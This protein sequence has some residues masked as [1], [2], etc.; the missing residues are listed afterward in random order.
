MTVAPR[1]WV[2]EIAPYR[3]GKRADDEDGGLASNEGS[4]IS[5]AIADAVLRALTTLHRYP[6]PLASD[7]RARIAAHHGVGVDEVLV[8]GG[9]D[10]LL[11]LL[12]LAYAAQGSV[13]CGDPGYWGHRIPPQVAGAEVRLVRLTDHRHDLGSMALVEADIAFI[14]NPHNPTGTAVSVDD[15]E[16]FSRS[17]RARL[18]V[19][20]EAYIECA[21]DPTSLSSIPLSTTTD[22]VVLRTF[23]KLYG[24][25]GA[26]VGYAVGPAAVIE[27]LAA[28]R[29]PFSVNALGQAAA[30]AALGDVEHTERA[31]AGVLERRPRLRAVF[32]RAGYRSV[33][34]EANFVLVLAPD[35]DGLVRK[36]ADGGVRVRP[37]SDLGVPGAVRVTVP[38]D[39]GLEMV[40]LAL[41]V[42]P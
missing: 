14:G 16:R 40:A 22:L 19:V 12:S 1:S 35:E 17:C 32:E 42:D 5:P 25:A 18:V 10:E 15:I 37:G 31:R 27:R 33:P 7:L 4:G 11:Y 34:S 13:V 29:P 9:S 23:S 26:R 41:G 21:T 6:D 8:G 3:A 24:L 36:L 30:I 39:R 2:S 28:I 20:D 38:S